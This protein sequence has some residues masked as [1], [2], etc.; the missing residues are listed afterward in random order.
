MPSGWQEPAVT[1]PAQMPSV[2]SRTLGYCVCAGSI[3]AKAPQIFQILR[4][5]SAAGLSVWM[6]LMEVLGCELN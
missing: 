3:F 2:L 4:A 6:P 5:G 1:H